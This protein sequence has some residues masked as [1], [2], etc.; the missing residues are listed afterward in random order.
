MPPTD[1]K[2]LKQFSFLWL[3]SA[4]DAMPKSIGAGN[5]YNASVITLSQKITYA[6]QRA[7]W[8]FSGFAGARGD[9]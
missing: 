1:G 6:D 5:I 8:S 9:L 7:Y 4:A 3:F 2:T